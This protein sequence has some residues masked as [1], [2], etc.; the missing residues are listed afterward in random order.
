MSY[1]N[2]KATYEKEVNKTGKFTKVSESY[3]VEAETFTEAEATTNELLK[4]RTPFTVESV[5]KVKLYELFLDN[6]SERYYKAKVGFITLDE[7]LGIERKK[8]VQMLVQA[9]DLPQA[10]SN[11]EKGMADTMSDYEV[12]AIAETPFV[13]VV[14]RM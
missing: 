7:R 9:D 14:K 13:D 10:L 8:Y 4:G 1:F 12:S 5:G 11:L 2:C 3:L 6:R